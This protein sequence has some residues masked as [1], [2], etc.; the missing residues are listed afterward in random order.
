MDISTA[1]DLVVVLVIGAAVGAGELLAQFRG[2]SFGAL[3][4]RPAW[5]YML[6]NGAAAGLA[7]LMTR[8]FGWTFGI[9]SDA[10]PDAVRL[11]QVVFAGFSAL[12]IFRTSLNFATGDQKIS[13]GLSQFLQNVLGA[14]DREVERVLAEGRAKTVAR[15]MAGVSFEKAAPAL[16]PYCVALMESVSPEDQR[17]LG[18]QTKLIIGYDKV[19]DHIKTLLLGLSL[20]NY[21][22]DGVVK[23]AV[24]SLG[25]E[26]KA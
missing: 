16:P 23:A 15:A 5:L 25:D 2:S 26:L 14:A 24:A 11:G 6:I 13:L 4:T 3:L 10:G 9:P 21:V 22:G 17:A 18:E 19:N 1:I 7:L 8:T 12:A 20:M